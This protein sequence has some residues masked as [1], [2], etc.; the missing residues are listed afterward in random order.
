MLSRLATGLK[1]A[2]ESPQIHVWFA[3]K[4]VIG[5]GLS[6]VPKGRR[7]PASEMAKLD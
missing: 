2:R 5:N 3:N 1:S 4:W 6:P 7:I